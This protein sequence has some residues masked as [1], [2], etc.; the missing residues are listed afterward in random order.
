[1]DA[2]EVGAAVDFGSLPVAALRLKDGVILDVN[3]AYVK[4]IGVKA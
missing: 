4:L 3:A 1:M 2:R